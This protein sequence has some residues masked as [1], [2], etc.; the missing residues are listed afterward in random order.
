[1]NSGAVDYYVSF[2]HLAEGVKQAQYLVEKFNLDERKQRLNVEFFSGAS[3]DNVEG[4]I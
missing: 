4:Y 2:D 1:M 3:S